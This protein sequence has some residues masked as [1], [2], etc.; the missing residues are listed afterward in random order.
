MKDFVKAFT[1]YAEFTGRSDRKEFWYYVLFVVIVGC[2]LSVLDAMLF[3][4]TTTIQSENYYAT[5]SFKP[6]SGLFSLICFIP[7]ISVSVRR[8]HDT[9]KSGWLYLLWFV[10]IIGWI[11]L[12]I[13]YCEK[14][15]AASNAHGN[16]P[17]GSRLV[18]EPS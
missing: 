2:I 10:P 9:G 8:L 1:R 16:P 12:L 5:W 4:H 18:T 17:E 7:N 15:D 11:L 14:G 6:L 3:G 13:W